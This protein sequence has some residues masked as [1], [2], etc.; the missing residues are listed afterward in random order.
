MATQSE[1]LS[2]S[3]GTTI[4]TYLWSDEAPAH[5]RGVVQIAHGLAEYGLRYARLAQAL[6][7][8][9]YKVY[10]NDHRGHGK[11]VASPSD[12]VNFGRA[13]FGGLVADVAQFGAQI[14]AE[15]QGLPLFLI[16]HSMGS[17]ASQEVVLDH[18]AQYA[19][20]VLS[21]TTAVDVCLQ[22]TSPTRPTPTEMPKGLPGW[23]PSM[24]VS[25]TGPVLSGCPAM[26]RRWT[27]TWPTR[28]SGGT[29]RRRRSRRCSVLVPGW[30]T[31]RNWRESDPICRS[32]SPPA[33]LIRWPD[34]GSSWNWWASATATQE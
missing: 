28:R 34:R 1:F 31:R 24:K 14:A 7:K 3:D 15:N 18:S 33:T 9:G 5:P 11:S 25:S 23:R 26:R 32:L 8:A 19:G 13:G 29:W 21:G 16:A 10:A 20:L 30:R 6:S 12:L 27:N 22:R 2:S 17:I 4:A